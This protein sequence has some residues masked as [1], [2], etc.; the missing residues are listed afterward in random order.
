[1]FH[2]D[3]ILT[4]F[5]RE[6]RTPTSSQVWCY[7]LVKLALRKLRQKDYYEVKATLNYIEKPQE[8]EERWGALK[9]VR[10]YN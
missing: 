9:Y 5:A 10:K 6:S 1:M 8:T 4:S 3:V 2:T 7:D